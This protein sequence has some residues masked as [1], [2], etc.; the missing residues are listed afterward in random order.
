MTPLRSTVHGESTMRAGSLGRYVCSRGERAFFG[1]LAFQAFIQAARRAL[2]CSSVSPGSGRLMLTAYLPTE[3]RGSTYGRA[4]TTRTNKPTPTNIHGHRRSAM[5]HS[6]SCRRP[7]LLLRLLRLHLPV[8]A[9][10]VE[11][12]LAIRLTVFGFHSHL[13]RHQRGLL[14]H[15]SSLSAL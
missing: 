4:G 10:I 15:L 3:Y 6:L 13:V 8:L 2:N 12:D 11:R 9:G 1:R 5:A 7:R 14:H